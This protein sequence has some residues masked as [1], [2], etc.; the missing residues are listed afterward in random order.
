MSDEPFLSRWARLKRERQ[1]REGGAAPAA[2]QTHAPNTALNASHVEVA[3]LPTD[4]PVSTETDE[5]RELTVAELP[6][7]ESIDASTDLAPWLKKKLPPDW[8]LAALRR[9]WAADPGI[10][11]FVGPSD[12]AWDWNAPDG[13][14]GFGPLRAADNVAN[15]LAQAIGK[16]TPP[17]AKA[18]DPAGATNKTRHEADMPPA[19]PLHAAADNS[20]VPEE[21]HATPRDA[22]AVSSTPEN[23]SDGSTLAADFPVTRRG[24]SALP[25]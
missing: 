4:Q 21:D 18:A 3:P 25:V 13:V 1:E 2:T 15:L 19:Q 12:Y 16:I 8:K 10:A 5:N 20:A 17:P 9:V 6:P 7:L 14:P 23:N 24:G 11:N 22:P